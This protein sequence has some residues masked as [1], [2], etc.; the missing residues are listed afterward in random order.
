MASKSVPKAIIW[1]YIL[2]GGVAFIVMVSFLF[3]I[4]SIEDVLNPDSNP[5]GFPVIYVLQ[6]CSYDG[7]IPLIAIILLVMLTGVIDSNAS[8]SRQLFAFARDGGLPFQGWISNVARET[9]PQNAVFITC[10][11]TILLSLI[12]LGSSIA[13]NAIISLQLLALMATYCISIG[14]VLYQRVVN[15]SRHLPPRQFD[16]GIHGT[17][18][19]A[20]AFVYSFFI[21]FWVPWPPARQSPFDA[22]TFNWSIIMFGGVSLVSLGYYCLHGRRSFAGPVT[23][24]RSSYSRD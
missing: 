11:I 18:L 15:K 9:V 10:A 13:F 19:N 17:W 16:L 14:C 20:V 7:A 6:N 1:S 3:A 2:N 4:P 24:V 8:T 22:K 12:N 5:S 21:M 23:L